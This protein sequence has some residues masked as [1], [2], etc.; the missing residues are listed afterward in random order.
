MDTRHLREGMQHKE[1]TAF[2][3]A[4]GS[5]E[6]EAWRQTRQV[7]RSFQGAPAARRMEGL[8]ALYDHLFP[9]VERGVTAAVARHFLLLPREITVARV[10][11]RA[12]RR[13]ELPA[14]PS[15]FL[16][17]VEA[18]VL[19]GVSEESGAPG[20]AVSCAEGDPSPRLR[21]WFHG[22]PA[23]DRALAWMLLVEGRQPAAAAAL[24]GLPPLRLQRRLQ[25]I[26][27]RMR[28]AGLDPLFRRSALSGAPP[29][30]NA[31][32]QP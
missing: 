19:A 16:L 23:R 3:P 5:G 7:F 21:A 20:T 2:V 31:E 18:E 12:V 11:A 30:E 32:E 27:E 29:S 24:L 1:E 22:L 8:A 15:V 9:W 28:E 6:E 26:E 4:A 10:L 13:R 14:H 17:W 25:E